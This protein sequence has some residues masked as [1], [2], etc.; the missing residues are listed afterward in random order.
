MQRDELV[1]ARKCIADVEEKLR[2]GEQCTAVLVD[3]V[4]RKQQHPHQELPNCEVALRNELKK[5]ESFV[6]FA[7]GTLQSRISKSNSANNNKK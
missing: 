6:A 2:I 5:N 3:F 4:A 7:K 1:A